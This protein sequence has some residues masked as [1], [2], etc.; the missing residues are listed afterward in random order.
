MLSLCL[1][2]LNWHLRVSLPVPLSLTHTCT[3][4]HKTEACEALT[5][6]HSGRV[7]DDSLE[8]VT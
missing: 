3:R 5:V 8:A 7:E 6:W 4:A 2:K 1:H